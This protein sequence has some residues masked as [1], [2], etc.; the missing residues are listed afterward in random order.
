[1]TRKDALAALAVFLIVLPAHVLSPNATPFDSRWT[2]PV[3]V[4]ILHQGNTDLDEYLPLLERDHFYAI[5]C[6]LPDGRRV[7]PL[8]SAADCPGGHFYNFYPAAVPALAAPAVWALEKGIVAAQ[9]ALAP[10]AARG[11]SAG[12]QTFLRGDLAGASMIVEL[13]IA[14]LL[15]AAASAV[16][17]LVARRFL[18]PAQSI[19]LALV[20]AFCTPAWSTASRALWQ[21]G[22]SM[23]LL[24]LAILFLLRSSDDARWIAPLGAV[25]A[26]AFYVRPTNA[27]TFAAL[28]LFVLLK[29]RRHFPLLLAGM[30]PVLIGFTMYDLRVYGTVLAPYSFVKR[31][32]GGGLSLHPA[33]LEALAG[34][35]ISPAR[36]LL[37]YT[38]L[39]LLAI[40]GVF[41]KP[42]GEAARSLRPY[43]AAIVIGHW[44]LISSFEQWSGGHC[45]GPR[46]F[47]D[48]TPIFVWFLIPVLLRPG[49]RPAIAFAALAAVSFFVH[50]RGAT[51]W[52]TMQW[53]VDPVNVDSHP[54]RIWDWKDPQFLRGLRSRTFAVGR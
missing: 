24:A 32:S 37:I 20:F 35:L 34:H 3:A 29:R 11:W 41:L 2:V 33:L 46:Y 5:E 6:I 48:M 54:G 13:L 25:L 28:S 31:S 42:P 4:S 26:L 52:S 27:V 7:F 40:G 19:L 30:A 15:V 53:N 1:L 18:R 49:R 38:P 14:S 45:Y 50:Y 16:M 23:L 51:Q 47:S 22:P 8:S 36:G 43:L 44:L 21:H 9:P 12:L 10:I 39:F 17:Y